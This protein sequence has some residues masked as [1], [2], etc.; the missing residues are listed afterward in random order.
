MSQ[1]PELMLKGG[2]ASVS[3]V[4]EFMTH[5]YLHVM[6]SPVSFVISAH[7]LVRVRTV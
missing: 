5:M 7:N 4:W 2:T 3:N 1:G 6:S